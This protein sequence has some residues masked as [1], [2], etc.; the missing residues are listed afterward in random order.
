M[1]LLELIDLYQKQEQELQFDTFDSDDALVIGNII[2][3]RAKKD[4]LTVL[5]DISVCD[6]ILFRYGKNGITGYNDIW[7]TRKQNTVKLQQMSSIRYGAQLR[8][9]NKRLGTEVLID[10]YEFAVCGG[11]FPIRLKNTG[12]VGCITVSGLVDTEDH[13]VIVDALKDYLKK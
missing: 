6:R 3:E 8:R 10:P 12:V 2:I 11:G 13:Q 5:V 9:D 7:V 4:N 1:E